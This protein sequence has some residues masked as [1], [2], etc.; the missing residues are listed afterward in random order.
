M[1][2]KINRVVSATEWETAFDSN[3]KEK[4]SKKYGDQ[5]GRYGKY[6]SLATTKIHLESAKKLFP[7]GYCIQSFSEST[8]AAKFD[9]ENEFRKM[10][11]NI[12]NLLVD[13]EEI[14]KI[15][16]NLGDYDISKY[17]EKIVI[18]DKSEQEVTDNAQHNPE[19]E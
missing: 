18:L 1:L 8:A 12:V 7:T 11:E 5:S 6:Y 3:E 13:C 4:I 10:Y 17:I 9:L 14:N 2:R 15:I 19:E 16:Q